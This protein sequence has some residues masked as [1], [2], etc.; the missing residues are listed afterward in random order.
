MF[1]T[2]NK[3]RCFLFLFFCYLIASPLYANPEIEK[4]SNGDVKIISP[5]PNTLVVNQAGIFFGSGA[6]V[7]VGG[8]I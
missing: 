4:I 6:K 7:D 3:A 8:I 5:S 2:N 1:C